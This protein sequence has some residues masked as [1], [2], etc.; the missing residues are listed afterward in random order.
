MPKIGIITEIKEIIYDMVGKDGQF[1]IRATGTTGKARLSNRKTEFLKR[2]IILM[3]D[4]DMLDAYVREYLTDNFISV[5]EFCNVVSDRSG[6]EDLTVA[7]MQSK[8]QVARNKIH[9][10]FG[11]RIVSD[12]RFGSPDITGYEDILNKCYSKYFGASNKVKDNLVLK[13]NEKAWRTNLTNE[14]FDELAAILSPYSKRQVEFVQ[15]MIEDSK[16]GYLNYLESGYG[17][18]ELD[19]ERLNKLKLLINGEGAQQHE[20]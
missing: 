4:S 16:V 13:L 6:K 9:G 2:F 1:K 18:S 11:S 19:Q 14:E 15:N 3:R 10:T 8:I 12:V 17:L 5:K 7:I 20:G